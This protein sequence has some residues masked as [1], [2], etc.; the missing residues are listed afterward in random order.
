MDRV[1][2]DRGSAFVSELDGLSVPDGGDSSAFSTSLPVSASIPISLP[3]SIPWHGTSNG[4]HPMPTS[5]DLAK[6][7]NGVSWLT[8]EPKSLPRQSPFDV[9]HGSTDE[10]HNPAQPFSFSPFGRMDDSIFPV[11]YMASS[12]DSRVLG[13]TTVDQEGRRKSIP[14][15]D[16]GDFLSSHALIEGQIQDDQETLPAMVDLAPS[17]T[18]GDTS[19]VD[20]VFDLP[21]FPSGEASRKRKTAR[22]ERVETEESYERDGEEYDHDC[23]RECV[24]NGFPTASD[25]HKHQQ[26]GMSFVGSASPLSV[27]KAGIERGQ[28]VSLPPSS[29]RCGLCGEV[30]TRFG[31]LINCRDIFCLSCIRHHRHGQSMEESR[32]CPLCHTPSFFVIPSSVFPETEA[33][34]D[35]VVEGYKKKLGTIPCKYFDEGRGT[36]PFGSSCFYS[37]VIQEKGNSFA[38]ESGS[39]SRIY[40]GNDGIQRHEDARLSD[41]IMASLEEKSTIRKKS[42]RKRKKGRGAKDDMGWFP[43]EK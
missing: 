17:W 38:E 23:G 1:S 42:R 27:G 2:E 19:S 43:D 7:E 9:L 10:V 6:S 41:F 20:S 14:T 18:P 13:T 32:L 26:Y 35:V 30:P 4:S 22:V 24:A 21:L 5:Y 37:H 3:K 11:T 12:T 25:V 8:R 33:E 28:S 39:A 36:C 31:L 16:F 34:K 15:G 29:L 40:I